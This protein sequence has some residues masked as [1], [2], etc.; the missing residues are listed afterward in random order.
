MSIVIVTGSAGLIGSEAALFYGCTGDHVVGID[1]DMRSY[2]FGK[3]A[4]TLLNRQ[5]VQRML[6]VKYQHFDLDIR[7]IESINNVFSNYNSDIALIIHTAAQ[8]SHD[9]AARESFTD[10]NVNGNGTLVLL[11]A[12]RKYCPNAVFIFT[13][14]NKVYGDRPNG[15]PLI[16]LGTRYEVHQSH[17]YHNGIPEDMSVDQSMH[18]LFGASKLAADVLVQEYGRYFGF[19]TACFR[20]GVLTGG[21]HSGVQLHG[22]LSYLMKC[23]MMD[24]SYTVIGYG[25]KQVRDIIHSRDVIC[26][27]DNFFKNPRIGEVYNIGGGRES[28]VS[29]IEAI[30]MAQD[31]TGKKI[32]ISYTDQNRLGDHMWYISDLTKLKTHYPGWRLQYNNVRLIAEEIYNHKNNLFA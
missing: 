12:M 17:P 1:N 27:L 6:G 20:G 16:E 21:H 4:S 25:G 30:E 14:T 5:H 23:A 18:S 22:F 8:P 31:I 10:F 28:N 19:K 11:E 3:E 32:K 15:L 24:I 7:D 9:W 26:A 29:V 2:F 13:S